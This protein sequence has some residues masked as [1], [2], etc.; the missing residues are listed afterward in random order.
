MG[1]A[2][3]PC[4]HDLD[5]VSG[6]AD[7]WDWQKSPDLDSVSGLADPWDWQNFRLLQIL[8]GQGWQIHGTGRI[9]LT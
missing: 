1:I 3:F 2:E 8:L 4:R 5:C 7:P 9:H 6:L